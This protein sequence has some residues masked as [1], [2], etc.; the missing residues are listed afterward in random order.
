MKRP[1]SIWPRVIATS[2]LGFLLVVLSTTLFTWWSVGPLK[3]EPMVVMVVSAGFRLPLL[4]AAVVVVFLGFL[5]DLLSGGIMGLQLAAY[6]WVVVVCAVA[7][8]KLQ[9]HSWPLQMLSVG[10]MTLLFQVLV[11]AGLYLTRREHLLPQNLAL[12]LAAQALLSAL[13]APLFFAWLEA[14]VRLA[15][16]LWP[17]AKGAKA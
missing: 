3:L 2:A 9:I 16:R 11:V 6:V 14:M 15:G 17:Q 5:A 13:T 12:V 10:L 1:E 8:R 4:P 7:E